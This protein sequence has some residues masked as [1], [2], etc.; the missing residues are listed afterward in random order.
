M[1]ILLLLLSI[2]L[3]VDLYVAYKILAISV[4]KD[5]LHGNCFRLLQVTSM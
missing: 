4:P 2:K 5:S 3:I 1:E